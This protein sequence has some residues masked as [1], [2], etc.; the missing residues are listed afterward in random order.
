MLG[1]TE[2]I[3]LSPHAVVAAASVAPPGKTR[4]VG[5]RADWGA[6]ATADA[7]TVHD[8]LRAALPPP[9]VRELY[10]TDTST[11]LESVDP[12]RVEK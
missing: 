7:P 10:V 8:A 6:L 12:S 5:G 11:V 2:A 9:V 4:R 3:P 1:V